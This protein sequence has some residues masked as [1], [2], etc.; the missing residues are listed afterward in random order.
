MR[1]DRR[2]SAKDRGYDAAWNRLRRAKLNAD[3]LCEE[4][5]HLGRVVR[6]TMVHH[7]QTIEAAPE[8]RLEWSNLMSLCEACHNLKHSGEA[9]QVTG[10][11]AT[12]FPTNPNH[13]WNKRR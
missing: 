3:P 1:P 6:A 11:D 10:A 13:P 12:G 5:N 4:C 2:P 8:L 7:I 9:K